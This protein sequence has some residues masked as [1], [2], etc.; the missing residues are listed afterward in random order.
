MISL[1]T[2]SV[3]MSEAPLLS[4]R[5]DYVYDVDGESVTEKPVPSYALCQ[6]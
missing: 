4:H 6:V 3:T 2:H 1:G 5:C